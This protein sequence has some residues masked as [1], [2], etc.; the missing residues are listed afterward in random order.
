MSPVP[1]P[2]SVKSSYAGLLTLELPLGGSGGEAYRV[3]L[4]QFSRFLNRFNGAF[5]ITIPVRIDEAM[6]L[7]TIRN[8]ALL[9]I[10]PKGV[11]AHVLQPH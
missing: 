3:D 5:R 1:I 11:F 9:R 2:G 6:L 4:H 10:S 7:G 8:L